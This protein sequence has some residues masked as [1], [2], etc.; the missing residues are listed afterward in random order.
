M[1]DKIVFD[2]RYMKLPSGL[3]SG[4][5]VRLLEVLK[6]PAGPAGNGCISPMRMRL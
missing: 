4:S 5:E 2:H 6:R 3:Y 1:I